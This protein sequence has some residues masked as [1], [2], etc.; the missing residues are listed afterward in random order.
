MPE[1]KTENDQ[2]EV[3]SSYDLTDKQHGASLHITAI[4]SDIQ[5]AASISNI[6]M[7]RLQA[8]SKIERAINSSSF[9][10][11]L[12]YMLKKMSQRRRSQKA[13]LL[14]MHTLLLAK[15]FDFPI[16]VPLDCWSERERNLTEMASGLLRSG[17]KIYAQIVSYLEAFL[18]NSC[19]AIGV[20]SQEE[21]TKYRVLYPNLMCPILVIP[22]R[23]F[24]SEKGM[25]W[26]Q[27]SLQ[28]DAP[29]AIWMDARTAYGR[30]S[31]TNCLDHLARLTSEDPQLAFDVTVISRTSNF[32]FKP[33]HRAVNLSFLEEL[34]SFLAAQSIVI[35]PDL[36]GSGIK[37]RALEAATIGLPIL[38]TATALEGFDWEP[39]D[40]HV[41]TWNDY[42]SFKTCI[43]ASI[44]GEAGFRAARLSQHLLR[45]KEA[46]SERKILFQRHVLE[47]SLSGS[48]DLRPL[49]HDQR[50][51]NVG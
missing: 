10:F 16:Y 6:I 3:F 29:V 35:L 4:M 1:S 48:T 5:Q 15:F 46:N 13:V 9:G 34:G 18:I 19:S 42:Q 51:K 44:N 33:E 7:R 22:E 28:K 37:N 26:K 49:R 39:I 20:V 21:A 32:S 38:A 14:G 41:L 12:Y 30:E 8:K 47:Y 43:I 17:R 11:S 27:V 25:K 50:K 24:I 23:T 36:F 40:E 31:V 2:L 45:L